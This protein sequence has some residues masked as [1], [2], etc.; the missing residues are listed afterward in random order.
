MV[1]IIFISILVF[2]LQSTIAHSQEITEEYNAEGMLK[3]CTDKV[4]DMPE[5]MQSF[6]CT[7]RLQGLTSI[8]VENCAS[9]EFGYEPSPLLSA[10]RPP[11]KGAIRQA[12]INFIEA[13]PD[14]WGLPWHHAAALAV[15]EAFPCSE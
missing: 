1:R 2:I 10:T 5:D 11:S 3:L 6:V 14:K 8:M 13:N 7:F 15:S 12:F 9:R 4:R